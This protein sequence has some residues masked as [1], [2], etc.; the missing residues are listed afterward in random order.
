MPVRFCEVVDILLGLHSEEG[1][2][3]CT[4]VLPVHKLQ[5]AQTRV[6]VWQSIIG[7]S[8]VHMPVQGL[9]LGTLAVTTPWHQRHFLHL[10]FCLLSCTNKIKLFGMN[11][12]SC[13]GSL[14]TDFE[15]T[16]IV[17]CTGYMLSLC[18]LAGAPMVLVLNQFVIC[19]HAM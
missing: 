9:R 7:Y 1:L 17:C 12:E 2:H 6:F 13:I 10:A 5:K 15:R 4:E 14:T 8:A 18:R 16:L 19:V 11:I 3:T